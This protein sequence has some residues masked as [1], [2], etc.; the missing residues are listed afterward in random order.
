MEKKILVIDDEPDF[1]SI[2]GV[3]LRKMGYTY[4]PAKNGEEALNILD[5]EKPDLVIIDQGVP[6]INEYE[7]V[8]KMKRSKDLSIIPIMLMTA[9]VLNVE[10]NAEELGADCF[11]YKP[12]EDNEFKANLK[13]LLK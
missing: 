4:L 13:K 1:L 8:K 9:R 2:I 5:K 3:R 6:I 7:I 10:K 11:M 12:F